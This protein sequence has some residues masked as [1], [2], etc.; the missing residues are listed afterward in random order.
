MARPNQILVIY[1]IV[2]AFLEGKKY[3]ILEASTGFGKSVAGVVAMRVISSLFPYENDSGD[4]IHHNSLVCTKTKA[5]QKQYAK[6]YPEFSSLWS[7]SGYECNRDPK[8]KEAYFGSHECDK[9]LCFY[10][11][12]CNYRIA[13]EEFLVNSEG[14]LNY[15]YF[16]HYAS[17]K[18]GLLVLDEAHNLE[19]VLVDHLHIKINPA[20]IK[21][22]L[23]KLERI[24][25]ASSYDVRTITETLLCI[26][27]IYDT[28][29]DWFNKIKEK[30]SEVLPVIGGVVNRYEDS[31]KKIEDN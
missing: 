2:K 26:T 11:D 9:K 17:H 23:E 29:K 31:K 14:I 30:C 15:A 25:M 28:D 5:L 16:M 12:Q 6:D 27:D 18:P 1:N 13:R 20:Y 4:T 19:K 24:K 21:S 8:N 22:V 7:S 10:F 3:F